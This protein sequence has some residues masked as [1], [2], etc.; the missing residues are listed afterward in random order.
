[1]TRGRAVAECAGVVVAPVSAG[2]CSLGKVGVGRE[3]RA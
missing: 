1:M 2:G 3:G